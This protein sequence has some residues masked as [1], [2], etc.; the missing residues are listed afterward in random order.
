MTA[1]SCLF[2]DALTK[3]VMIVGAGARPLLARYRAAALF[4]SDHGEVHITR[5]WASV[6]RRAS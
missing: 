2:A 3:V 4:L 5:E 6:V 1:P